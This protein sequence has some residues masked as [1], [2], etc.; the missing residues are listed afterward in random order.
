MI[1]LILGYGARSLPMLREILDEERIDGL[2]LT[3]QNCERELEGIEK[4]DVI[5]IYAHELPEIV[6]E[7][8]KESKAKVIACAGLES[9]TTVPEEVLIKAKTYYVLGGKKN[10]RNLVRFLASLAGAEIDY[11]DPQEVPMHGIYHPELGLFESLDEYLKAYGKG[12]LIGVLFWRSAW[13]YKEFGPIGEL[14]RALEEEGFGVIPVF[15]YGKDSRTG[16]GREKSE[17]VEEFFMKD[18][19]PVVEALISLISFGTVELK[20]LGRLNVPVFAPI[21]SYYQSV[22]DWKKGES[23]DYMT[24]VYGVIIPEVAGAIEPIFV[25]GTRNVEGYKKDEPYEEHIRYLA[26]RVKKWVELRKKPRDK[27]RIAIV[28]INPP[29][30]GLEANVAVGLGLD[31]PESIVRLLHRLKEEGYYVGEDL[32]ENGEELIK[33]ILK[34]KAISEFR[35]TSVGEIVKSGGAI[36]FVG[37]E[38]YLE[39]FNELPGDLRER[40][41]RDW[42]KPEEI[43]AGKVD[44]ALVG[45]VYDRKFVV[46]GIRF[47]NVLITPQPKFGCAGARCDG[48]VCRIL[49][50]PTITPPHQWWA[51]YRWIT[52][53]FRADVMIHF[54]THGYLEFRPGKGVGLSPSCVPE[55]SLDDVPHIYVYAVSNPMEGVIAKRRG[56]AA[57][58]DHIYPPMGMA[59]VL[60]DLDSLLTQYAKAKSLGDEARRK[61]IYE[62]ILEKAKENRLRIADPED[63]ER[64]IEEIHRYVELM[65]G[66]QINL[67]LHIFGYP[68]NEPER[69]AEY[70]ATAMAYDSYASPSIKRVIAEAVGLDYDEL[71]K[72]PLGTTNGFTN[73]EL[74]EVFHR[75]AV[76]SLERLLEGESFEVVGEEIEKF[77]F[78][79]KEKEKLE[80]TFRKALEVAEKIIGCKKEH[81]GFLKGLKG[82]YVEPG[83]SG[84]ITRGKFEILP[85]GRNFYAVDPRTLPTKAA[86]QIGVETAEKLLEEYMKKHGKYPESVGQVLWSIDGYKADGEQ[87]AQILYLI[88]VRPVWK[89]DVVAGL[90]VIPPEELGRPRIDVLVRI[91]GI[92]RDTLPNYIY[93]IDEA[94][95]KVVTLDEPP[96]MNYIRKH[97]VE[98]IKKLIELGKSFE[99]AQRFARFRVFSAPPGAYGVGVN[100]AVESSGWR[101]DEDLAKV[102]IQWS[103]YAYGKDASGVEAY[104]SLVLNLKEVDVINRNHISDEHDPTNCCCYFAHHG[105]FKAAVDALT[106]KNAEVVQTDTR[107]IS[108]TKIVE[109]KVELERVVRAKLLNERWIEEMK[110]HGYR[111]AEFSKKINHLYGWEATT[112]L[113]EDWVFDEIAGKYVLDEEMRRWF[114]EHN[115]YA[116]EEIARRLIEAYERGLWET[117]EELIER[118]MEVYSE[119]EGIL[120]ESL[121]EGEVQG[122]TIEIYTAQDDEHWNEK[123]KEVDKIWSLVKND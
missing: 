43:L 10:L 42:G 30:K 73:R 104:D 123:I 64:T 13:L 29:C 89:G 101:S 20:N 93:L 74:L 103:G 41:V 35:W 33:L 9:L 16:L 77:G 91:S 61:K 70:V 45:M 111:A 102:W 63:E 11:E 114:E 71:K 122:G 59:E 58:V 14:I 86:W 68:P 44:K 1:C 57:L 121:G 82:E 24:Q 34:R 79:V 5:F 23:V 98:H 12:P 55:A 67:G 66:S 120:E 81:E 36:D 25:A 56:Y 53:K 90:E 17:A 109:V 27:V 119:I 78:K 116:I 97:Y 105:G 100:L 39:W 4:S 32:P 47:G 38:E 22:E 40:I 69:L 94:I 60:D 83:P 110:K 87:I 7:R 107:D 46:P 26:R 28:L 118:L 15:T 92:V 117:S 49:H 96:E 115:P 2:V 80:E 31:V 18:G 54:G 6:E 95:E 19:T 8:I 108:D 106:G 75:I 84:A 99:E 72:N 62:Q 50:D 65:R 48:K 21:R 85:T 37:L 52:R 113:V 51:V 76:K 88:G 112:K 3:D